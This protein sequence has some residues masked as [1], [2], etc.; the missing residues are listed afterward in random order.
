[1]KVEDFLANTQYLIPQG[2]CGHGGHW[3]VEGGAESE[4]MVN[5]QNLKYVIVHCNPVFMKSC[6]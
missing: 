4:H 6:T 3:E 5:S 2:E 1:V